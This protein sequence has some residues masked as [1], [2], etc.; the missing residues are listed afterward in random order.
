MTS[1]EKARHVR[2]E[3]ETIMASLQ[4]RQLGQLLALGR[5][6]A[7]EDAELREPPA[8]LVE[9]SDANARM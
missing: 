2:A 5:R 8:D 4:L 7:E 1:S 6:L 9:T 3:L